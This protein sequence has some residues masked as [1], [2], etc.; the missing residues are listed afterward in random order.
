MVAR[1]KAETGEMAERSGVG[2]MLNLNLGYSF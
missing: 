2:P 1:A